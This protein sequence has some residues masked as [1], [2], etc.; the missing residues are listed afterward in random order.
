M[1]KSPTIVAHILKARALSAHFLGALNDQFFCHL[2][3]TQNFPDTHVGGIKI[4]Y[5]E[6]CEICAYFVQVTSREL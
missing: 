3:V 1:K 4:V 6:V 2:K 5:F